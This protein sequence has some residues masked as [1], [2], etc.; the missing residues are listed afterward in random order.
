MKAVAIWRA[1]HT[2]GHAALVKLYSERAGFSNVRVNLLADG[3]S[4]DPL[5]AVT[6]RA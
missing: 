3:R 1:L 2:N 6:A 5:V 4:G